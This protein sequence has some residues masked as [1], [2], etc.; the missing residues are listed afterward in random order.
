MNQMAPNII[1]LFDHFVASHGS[2][3]RFAAEA[4]KSGDVPAIDQAIAAI[5]RAPTVKIITNSALTSSAQCAAMLKAS[6][7]KFGGDFMS[8]VLAMGV[9]GA[10]LAEFGNVAG[11]VAAIVGT[12]L[13]GPLTLIVAVLLILWGLSRAY[14]ALVDRALDLMRDRV[15]GAGVE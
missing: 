4:V 15:R 11:A 2:Y 14:P 6:A 3:I 5:R 12:A 7:A 13:A 8:G 9:G 1:R 10:V